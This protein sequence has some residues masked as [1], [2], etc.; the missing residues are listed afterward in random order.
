MVKE[1]RCRVEN[2]WNGNNRYSFRIT[3][4]DGERWVLGAEEGESW[5]RKRWLA[6]KPH[7]ARH[8][9]VDESKVKA[10]EV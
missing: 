8:Y 6:L 1:I 5:S 3:G 4:P 10:D 2:C 7:I 9:G